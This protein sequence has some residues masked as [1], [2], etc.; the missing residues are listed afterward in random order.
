M[1]AWNAEK[2]MV[3]WSRIRKPSVSDGEE[4]P[5]GRFRELRLRYVREDVGEFLHGALSG[6]S[7]ADRGD[8]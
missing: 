1:P 8:R 6:V 4:R 3:Q 7:Q 5:P 2:E